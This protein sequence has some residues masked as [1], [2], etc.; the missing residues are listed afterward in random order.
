MQTAV[1][2]ASLSP[3]AATAGQYLTFIVNG[4]EYGVEILRVQ[5]IHGWDRATHIPNAPDYVLGVINLRGEI[6]PVV[7]LRRR[8]GLPSIAFGPTTVVV[9]V[10]VSNGQGDRTVGMVVDAISDVYQLE[11]GAVQPPPEMGIAIDEEFVDGLAALSDK[12]IILL[13]IDRLIAMDTTV[14]EV[15]TAVGA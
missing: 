2:Q 10:K 3:E 9:I 5:G 13:D 14:P 7:D 15:R 6:V 8:L 12:M 11:R 1:S 4:Q